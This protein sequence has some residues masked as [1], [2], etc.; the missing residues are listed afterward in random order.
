MNWR[1]AS[2]LKR[3]IFTQIEADKLQKGSCQL[4]T[5]KYILLRSVL[6][7][8]E[9]GGIIGT[10]SEFLKQLKEHSGF[11]IKFS[12]KVNSTAD[13]VM[14][15]SGSLH[16]LE[17]TIA[18]ITN[19]LTA[20]SQSPTWTFKILVPI[21]KFDEI[22]GIESENIRQ[23]STMT[24]AEIYP[25]KD[26]QPFSTEKIL[27]VRG[28]ALQLAS[29]WYSIAMVI[30]EYHLQSANDPTIYYIPG[31][32]SNDPL[33]QIFQL[34]SQ[35]DSAVNINGALSQELTI[36]ERFVGKVIGKNGVSIKEINSL[37]G[38]KILV[39]RELVEGKRKVIIT[40]TKNSN[41]RAA[42]LLQSRID[43]L[44]MSEAK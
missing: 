4:N 6:S 13:R 26:M 27:G 38:S 43:Y 2:A 15:L 8:G 20:Q 42:Q 37:S 16:H 18:M 17:S 35:L 1:G 31:Y 30:G 29:I 44:A 28:N 5:S 34:D 3:L 19:R 24:G 25:Y 23:L 22:I 32:S 21:Q 10:K 41:I 36:P 14:T 9:V 40:G 7:N 11:K 12:P 33:P 39:T